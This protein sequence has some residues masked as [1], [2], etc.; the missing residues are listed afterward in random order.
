MINK[1]MLK[2]ITISPILFYYFSV[3]R[4]WYKDVHLLSK[5]YKKNGNILQFLQTA[6][7]YCFMKLF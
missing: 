3:L 5:L 2:F 6:Q 1:F 7:L 4:I